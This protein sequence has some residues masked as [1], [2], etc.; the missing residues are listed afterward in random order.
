M[1]AHS[2]YIAHVEDPG[3]V[4]LPAGL[5]MGLLVV[6][7][8]GALGW[9]ASAASNASQAWQALLLNYL[10]F[11]MLGL[12]GIVFTAI[13]YVASAR[14][15]VAV[16]RIAEGMS[17]FVPVAFAFF[18]I[19]VLFGWG[20][21]YGGMREG[22]HLSAAK[23]VYI[24]QGGVIV[25][26]LLFFAAWCVFIYVIMKNS[27]TQDKNRDA[28]LSQKNIRL[29]ILFLIVF[30]ASFSLHVVDLLMAL[31]P[32]WFSTMFG[33]Y[34]FAG[35][36]L[37]TMCVITLI[38][39]AMRRRDTVRGAI[40]SRQ[41]YDLGTWIMAFSCFMVYIGFSQY[42]LIWYANLPEETFYMIARTQNGWEFVTIL[43]PLLKWIIPFLV[44]MPQPFRGNP[45]VLTL[46]CIAVL[47]GQWI[48][49]Y[50]MIYPVFSR[51]SP[52]IPGVAE[53]GAFLA[54]LGVFGWSIDWF[55]RRHSVL[56]IGDPNLVSSVNGSY[57]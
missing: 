10:F 53:I 48:D 15:S 38:T 7:I 14:W 32:K 1:Q 31:E 25:K 37:S 16:R 8:L 4:G 36:F 52:V 55:Y 34:C 26:G 21:L 27:L 44:L 54:I 13:Q 39:L 11:L 40:Q 2:R 46:V 42:M 41:L 6:S 28:E 9:L 24:S 43:L 35:L 17:V 29:S 56:P 30:A 18:L 45:V 33:V 49:I 22:V 12:G 50:W 57:L 19:I 3:P 51:E 23:A 47:V 20:D 5:R